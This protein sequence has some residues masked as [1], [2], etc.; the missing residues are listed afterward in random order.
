MT[1]LYEPVRFP[2]HGGDYDKDLIAL[3]L[4]FYDVLSDPLYLL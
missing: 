2:C 4:S 1:E 3:L